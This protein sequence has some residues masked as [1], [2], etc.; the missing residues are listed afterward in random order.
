MQRGGGQVNSNLI[1]HSPPPGLCREQEDTWLGQETIVRGL[2]LQLPG[3]KNPCLKEDGY[4][5]SS[6]GTW[7]RWWS[8]G[9]TDLDP[10]A[11]LILATS[12]LSLGL[13]I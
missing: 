8:C 5:E 11:A 1:F 6:S 9:R 2:W 12:S 3:S 10:M 4:Q 7:N 13:R